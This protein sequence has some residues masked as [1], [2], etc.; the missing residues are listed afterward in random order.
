MAG[1]LQPLSDNFKIV[2]P[3]GTPTIYFIQWAQQKQIDISAGVTAAQAQQL[4]DDWAAAR[5]VI[6]GTGLA[7]GGSLSSDVTIDLNAGLDDLNDVDFS[8]LPTDGQVMVYNSGLG[9]W[10]PGDQTGSGGGGSFTLIDSFTFTGSEATYTFA[11]IPQTYKDLIITLNARSDRAASTSGVAFRL[12]GDSGGNYYQQ[13]SN[14]SGT[15]ANASQGLGGTS[16]GAIVIPGASAAA[17]LAGARDITLHD[18]TNSVFKKL[19]RQ[20]SIYATGTGSGGM[21]QNITSGFW[22]STSAITDVEV[23]DTTPS[24]FTE[25]SVVSLYGRGG[26]GGGSGLGQPE[27]QSLVSLGF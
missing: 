7:G 17:D 21:T 26:S 19:Y 25:G 20:H 6:A 23:F 2:N 5:Q 1:N 22:N 13:N 16:G 4:I 27:V 18:Y 11:S 15:T 12:N 24:N 14:Q 8:T 9:L 3:D 10:L